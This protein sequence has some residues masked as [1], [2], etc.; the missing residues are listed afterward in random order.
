MF[1]IDVRDGALLGHYNTPGAVPS[2]TLSDQIDPDGNAILI[3]QGLTGD[4]GQTAGKLNP[5]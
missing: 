2:G 1:R 4:A 3:M 5:G